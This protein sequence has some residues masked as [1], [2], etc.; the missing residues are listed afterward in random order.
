L[1]GPATLVFDAVGKSGSLGDAVQCSVYGARVVLVGMG[2]PRVELSAYAVST[3]ERSLVGSF[4]FSADDFR[5][6][7]RWVARSPEALSHLIDGRVDM[8]GAPDAFAELARG[9]SGTSKILVYPHGVPT[10]TDPRL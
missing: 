10:T 5:E 7:A 2:S 8:H 6:T 4:C 9:D 1:G 3:E